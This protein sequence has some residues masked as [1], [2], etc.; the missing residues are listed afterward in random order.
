MRTSLIPGM[1]GTMDLNISQQTRNLKIFEIGKIFLN[2][3]KDSLPEEVE[4]ISGLWTGLRQEA[5]WHSKEN[6]CDFYDIKGVLEGLFTC[7]KLQNITFTK[8]PEKSLS[9]TK[10]GYSADIYIDNELIGL[11]VKK[12]LSTDKVSLNSRPEISTTYADASQA[13]V[14]TELSPNFKA[15][16]SLIIHFLKEQEEKLGLAQGELS[17]HL[18]GIDPETVEALTEGYW[19]VEQTSERIFNFVVAAAGNDPSK[20]DLIKEEIDHGM[21]MAKEAFGGQLPEI[22]TKTYNAVMDKLDA[23]AANSE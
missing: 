19:G 23:W 17:G 1:L 3:D 9:Y 11:T 22:S 7:L 15:L 10:A 16:R 8:T 21:E 4:M 5:S 18:E 20:L 14:H 2:K 12:G 13:Q 6:K